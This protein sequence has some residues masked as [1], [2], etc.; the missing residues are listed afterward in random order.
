MIGV[1]CTCGEMLSRCPDVAAVTHTEKS[2]DVA[3]IGLLTEYGESALLSMQWESVERRGTGSAL[4]SPDLPRPSS[5]DVVHPPDDRHHKHH[6][7]SHQTHHEAVHCGA[8]LN[9]VTELTNYIIASETVAV[10]DETSDTLKSTTQEALKSMMIQKP[11]YIKT[12]VYFYM[13]Y[14]VAVKVVRC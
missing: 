3:E 4:S 6:R 11:I 14:S 12:F 2:T 9:Y 13:Y 8:G 1:V 10:V 5:S 7:P